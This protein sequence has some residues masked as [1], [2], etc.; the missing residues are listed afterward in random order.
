MELQARLAAEAIRTCDVFLNGR[1]NMTAGSGSA[2][3][4]PASDLATVEITRL[5]EDVRAGIDDDL[6]TAAAAAVRLAS[7]LSR[8]HAREISPARGGLA[9]WQGRKVRR[10]I[11]DHLDEPL[12]VEDLAKLVSLSTCHFHRA[13]KESFGHSP[14]AYIIK[15]RIERARG[16]MLMTSESLSQIALA[17][18]LTDEAHL[19]R[20]FRQ[21]T[22]M[23]PG[24]WRRRHATGTGAVAAVG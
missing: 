17:C 12:P 20:R 24:A 8:R 5:L 13:F 10:H 19:C 23:T 1:G 21:E 4:R 18:G 6:A 9:P 22:G 11:E 7:L 15:T 14:H 16:L 3:V 2:P